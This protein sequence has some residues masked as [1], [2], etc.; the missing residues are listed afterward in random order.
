MEK[1]SLLKERIVFLG[2]FIKN[3]KE[4][5]SITPSSKYL[6]RGMLGNINFKKAKYIAEY[7]AGTGA[8][9]NALLKLTRKD[10]IILCFETN[11]N[12]CLFLRKTIKD[13]RLVIINDSAEH[14]NDY[15]KLHHIPRIDYVLSSLPFSQ[16]SRRKKQRIMAATKDALDEE[17]K[18]I[19]YRYTFTFSDYLRHYFR[20]ISKRF[21]PLNIPPTFIYIC[22]K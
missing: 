6:K 22:Q 17:G 9:T 12:F 16:L 4:I 21:V 10:A 8:I 1:N 2:N 3:P 18:F 19:L 5:G 11:K 14:I 15:L 7:G 13:P 20:S